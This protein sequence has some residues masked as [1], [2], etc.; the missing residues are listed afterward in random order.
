VRRATACVLLLML[1]LAGCGGESSRDDEQAAA[2]ARA[3]ARAHA[4]R[5]EVGRAVFA[6]HCAG[7]HTIEGRRYTDPII[8]WEAPNLDH[9]KLKRRYVTFRVETGGP[10]MASFMGELST[11]E[12]GA[13]VDY[14]MET[15]GNQVVEDADH[16]QEL[17]DE[18]RRLFD[19]NCAACHG[20]AGNEMT[21][22]PT[23]PG[24]DFNLVKPSERYVIERMKDGVLPND[25]EVLMPSFR[26]KLSDAQMR[27][28]A[29]YVTAVAKE[30]PEAPPAE[31][32]AG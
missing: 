22:R 28:V 6:E 2:R 23:Y 8:E 19:Q 14:L 3:E 1:A 25:P 17:L 10:A 21:G 27:A 12:F 11:E 15:A 30:G 16:P 18:G 32:E 20:I 13:I 29:A 5:M 24:M 7:C 26:G 4:R 9:V 31:T